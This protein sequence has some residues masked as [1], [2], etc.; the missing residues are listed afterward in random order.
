MKLI[1]FVTTRK[2]PELLFF[3]VTYCCSYSCGSWSLWHHRHSLSH[4]GRPS[5]I[6]RG[7]SKTE[8]WSV[9]FMIY[10]KVL[11]LIN[12]YWYC[13]DINNMYCRYLFGHECADMLSINLLWGLWVLNVLCGHILD[14]V[15]MHLTTCI[16]V[17]ICSI[18]V[19]SH[20]TSYWAGNV[21]VGYWLKADELLFT[22]WK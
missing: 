22:F 4:L 21:P 1:M 8:R 14:I 13:D 18:Y 2:R 7:E 15:R 3:N 20:Y 6:E 11:N 12:I 9:S 19:S 5:C 10:K 16:S 17:I